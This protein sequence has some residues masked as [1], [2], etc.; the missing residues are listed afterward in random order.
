MNSHLTHRLTATAMAGAAGL[1]IAGFTALGSTFDYP[2]ILKSPTAE[3]LDSYRQ[4][5][6]AITGWF[7][8]LVISAALLAPI[9]VHLGRIAGGKLGPWIAGLGIAA[10][11]VQ[12]IGLSRW[13][14]FVPGISDDA[15]VPSHTANAHHTFE[16]LH[17]WLGTVLGETIGYALT[18]TFTALVVTAITRVIAPRWMTYLGYG[19][20]ALI[21]T[22]VAVPL[23]LE[24]ASLTNFAGYIAWCFWL[25]A[26]AVTL[27][28][29]RLGTPVTPHLAPMAA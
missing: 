27:W 13:V 24:A 10:A 19:S 4:H 12:V 26:M 5:Q 29:T 8:V 14:L 1:A 16:L 7:L 11:T 23:G 28:R 17:T 3:I 21:A 22:G 20:A 9:G 18:A 2:K 6:G 25:I 15:A